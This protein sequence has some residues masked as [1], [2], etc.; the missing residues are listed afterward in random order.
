MF[1]KR[2]VEN[3]AGAKSPQIL[4]RQ[5]L[6]VHKF[7]LSTFLTFH[8]YW[9]S[10]WSQRKFKRAVVEEW[11]QA[12]SQR[13]QRQPPLLEKKETKSRRRKKLRNLHLKKQLCWTFSTRLGAMKLRKH[14]FLQVLK[15]ALNKKVAVLWLWLDAKEASGTRARR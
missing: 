12:L 5:L 4:T 13:F 6:W 3:V 9:L 15:S 7:N 8:R 11:Y 1:S 2:A 14:S 10:K